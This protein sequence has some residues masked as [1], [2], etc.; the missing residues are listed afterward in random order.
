M[1]AVQNSNTYGKPIQDYA[2]NW[3]FQASFGGYGERYL[4][5]D[6]WIKT[7]PAYEQ[8]RKNDV[9]SRSLPQ[10]KSTNIFYDV[11]LPHLIGA[12][13]SKGAGKALAGGG[14]T[15]G[16][17]SLMGSSE[18]VSGGETGL[19]N[20]IAGL[21]K[22]AM[23]GRKNSKGFTDLPDM[24]KISQ[25][26]EA[27]RKE[28][29]KVN[30]AP[31]PSATFDPNK[32]ATVRDTIND[33]TATVVPTTPAPAP[34]PAPAPPS[35]T[36]NRPPPSYRPDGDGHPNVPAPAPET[37]AGIGAPPPTPNPYSLNATARY[38]KKRGH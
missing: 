22:S 12:I 23:G 30:E 9:A 35:D 33:N 4:P 6:E 17:G 29:K 18:A 20:A 38:R 25:I 1:V 28:N 7:I 31:P 26:V 21:I 37:L 11:V 10:T 2:G 14:K 5:Y 27:H 3:V 36:V 16:S 8:F 19:G 24:S 34:A 13:V 15:G 32:S